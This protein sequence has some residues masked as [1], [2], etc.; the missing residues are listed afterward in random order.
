M[1]TGLF[2]G[3]FQ[4]FH[5]GHLDAIKQILKICDHCIILVGSAQ[6][7]NQPDNPFSYEERKAMIETTLKKENIQNWSI[8][9][10]DDIRDN[11]LWVEY[12]D[13]NTPKYDVVYTGNPLTEKLFS[14]AGYPVRKLDINIK[15]SGRE[16]R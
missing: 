9:P 6:Y 10:I 2:L 3:R 7:K 15:I 11:D 12:V 5:L 13:K 8:I 4:P 16:L 14:K 1:V